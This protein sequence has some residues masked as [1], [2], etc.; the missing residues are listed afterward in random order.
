MSTGP[1]INYFGLTA[2]DNKA[3]FFGDAATI[4]PEVCP[5]SILGAA[6]FRPKKGRREGPVCNMAEVMS[7]PACHVNDHQ[8]VYLMH[9]CDSENFHV[10]HLGTVALLWASTGCS[11]CR[12]AA[13]V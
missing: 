13:G 4:L 10:L 2:Y 3:S 7:S 8:W 11:E 6:S 12:P 9:V 5:K 1:H